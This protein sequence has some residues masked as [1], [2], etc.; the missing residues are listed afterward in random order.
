[1]A[2]LGPEHVDAVVAACQAGAAEAAAA[3]TRAFEG[4][5]QL[6]PPVPVEQYFPQ[7]PRA[8]WS[9]G[10]LI[11]VAG[12]A[13]G[14]VAMVLPAVEGLLPAWCAEPDESGRSRLS[15][16]AQ[17]L[18]A[19][20]LPSEFFPEQCGARWTSD[21]PAT[22]GHCG[23]TPGAPLVTLPV[24]RG[25]RQG[26]LTLLW[27]VTRPQTVL[28][29]D[30]PKAATEA[31]GKPATAKEQHGPEPPHG[32]TAY[33]RLEDALPQLPVYSRSL[34]K[35][36]TPVRVTLAST[37]LPVRTIVELAPGSLIQFS[38]TCDQPLELEVGQQTVAEGEAVKVGEKFGLRITAIALPGERFHPIAKR[39]SRE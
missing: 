8:S 18:A 5:F 2:N 7:S 16:L 29:G 14:H 26:E 39:G 27:P 37:R 36:R 24:T 1:M 19:T 4:E 31:A 15:T 33:E 32:R 34:L 13:A 3:L 35:I 12:S 38:K 28:G 9:A 22:I 25:E 30:G 6:S 17:E 11:L 10:G 23:I 20:L 21:L